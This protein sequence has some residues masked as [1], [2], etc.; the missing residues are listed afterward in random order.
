[1][2]TVLIVGGSGF[3]G[4]HLAIRLR[5]EFKVIATHFRHF[6]RIPGVTHYPMSVSQL[7]WMKELLLNFEPDVILYA[8]GKHSLSWTEDPAHSKALELAHVAGPNV[9]LSAAQMMGT[10]FVYLSNSYVFD[11]SHGNHSE[12]DIQ[13]PSTALGKAKVSGENAVK[14]RA[15]NYLVVRSGPLIGRGPA[16]NPSFL[17]LWFRSWGA[18][19]PV[20][21]D[22]QTLHSYATVEEFSDWIGSCLRSGIKNK[23]LHFGGL[24]KCTEYRLGLEIAQR[25]KVP[26]ALVRKKNT[27][28]SDERVDYSLNSSASIKTLEVKP[29]LLKQ[30]LD[31]VQK[32]LLV[33]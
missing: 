32:R 5:D 31:L 14:N 15:I 23:V 29:L 19:R 30:S 28:P 13:L 10:K 25:F 9:L 16:K 20:E 2:K 7:D 4:S 26:A 27:P 24:S 8:A 11:A 1:V 22:D 12:T 17:D 6:Q 33:P 21:L 18:G 3:V